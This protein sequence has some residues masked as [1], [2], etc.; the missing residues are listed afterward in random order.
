MGNFFLGVLG[1][2]L[3]YPF[4]GTVIFFRLAGIDWVSGLGCGRD[5]KDK[6]SSLVSS[7]PYYFIFSMPAL[8]NICIGRGLNNCCIIML[9]FFP[10]PKRYFEVEVI[11]PT[12][13]WICMYM[14]RDVQTDK[15]KLK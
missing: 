13:R 9:S 10:P 3:W 5:A 11:P 15:I 14:L 8:G 7:I 6:K 4:D 1:F 12:L 2:C